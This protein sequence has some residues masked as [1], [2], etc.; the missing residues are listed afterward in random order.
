MERRRTLATANVVAPR[1]GHAKM[2]AHE[3]SPQL[4]I[5]KMPRV[6]NPS[7]SAAIAFTSPVK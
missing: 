1:S 2:R 4:P 6:Y 5:P 7:I 3:A